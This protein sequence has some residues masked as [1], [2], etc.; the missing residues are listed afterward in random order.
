MREIVMV[1]IEFWSENEL[2]DVGQLRTQ[3][4]LRDQNPSEKNLV[5]AIGVGYCG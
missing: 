1:R 3:G 4:R 2:G 5:C